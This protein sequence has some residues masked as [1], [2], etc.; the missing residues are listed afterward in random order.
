MRS[1]TFKVVIENDE[2]SDGTPAYHAYVPA[3]RD[4]GGSTWGHTVVEALANIHVVV[5]LA[6]EDMVENGEPIP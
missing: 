3:L 1:Y 6:L 2:F 4:K 5:G